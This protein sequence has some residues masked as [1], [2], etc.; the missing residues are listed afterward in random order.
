MVQD[1]AAPNPLPQGVE[2][3]EIRYNRSA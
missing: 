2:R 1:H 3:S